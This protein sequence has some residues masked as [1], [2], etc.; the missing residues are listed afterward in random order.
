MFL[1]VDLWG[2]IVLRF[3]GGRHA[4]LYY[5]GTMKAS[6]AAY[7]AFENGLVE[8]KSFT[9]ML[10][11]IN[12]ISINVQFPQFF[13]CPERLIKT[14]RV[15]PDAQKEDMDFR[16]EDYDGYNLNNC[17]GLYYEADHAFEMIKQGQLFF[18]DILSKCQISTQIVVQQQTFFLVC[19]RV[20]LMSS[21][22]K[23]FVPKIK[24]CSFF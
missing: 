9:I 7:L 1:G 20:C 10:P 12:H 3:K 19:I 15:L 21:S 2:N 13:W 18:A 22:I 17:A 8:V 24:C 11:P 16:L 23:V 5:N 6:T 14:T 4:L